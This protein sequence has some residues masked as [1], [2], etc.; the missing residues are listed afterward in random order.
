VC[1]RICSAVYS[2]LEAALN[3]VGQLVR[4]S[5]EIEADRRKHV[6]LLVQCV[7]DDVDHGLESLLT[8]LHSWCALSPYFHQ[9]FFQPCQQMVQMLV[10]NSGIADAF[11]QQVST[12]LQAAPNVFLL[13]NFAGSPNSISHERLLRTV[14]SWEVAG[15][16]LTEAVE[17]ITL[18]NVNPVLRCEGA[19]S[20]VSGFTQLPVVTVPL[21]TM[22]HIDVQME[23]SAYMF[24]EIANL[25]SLLSC[26]ITICGPTSH[27]VISTESVAGAVV[28]HGC[29]LLAKLQ[30]L[31][32][33]DF[34]SHP[35][36]FISNLPCLKHLTSKL[37]SCSPRVF[38]LSGGI[39]S[40][41]SIFDRNCVA[42][43][44]G[45][46]RF[47]LLSALACGIERGLAVLDVSHL[48]SLLT[49]EILSFISWP[50]VVRTRSDVSFVAKGGTLAE[51]LVEI[52][53][54][55]DERPELCKQCTPHVFDRW[56]A[57]PMIIHQYQR[58]SRLGLAVTVSYAQF[59][60]VVR[61]V[62]V[63]RMSS[64][65]VGRIVQFAYRKSEPLHSLLIGTNEGSASLGQNWWTGKW[66]NLSAAELVCSLDA[67]SCTVISVDAV[68]LK[69][70]IVRA[71][72]VA[73]VLSLQTASS[74]ESVCLGTDCQVFVAHN[75]THPPRP[76]SWTSLCP[77]LSY[78]R[79][80]QSRI[81][82]SGLSCGQFNMC[83]ELSANRLPQADDGQRVHRELI[84]GRG[85]APV[86]ATNSPEANDGLSAFSDLVEDRG[87][88]M[89][90]L[91]NFYSAYDRMGEGCDPVSARL[92]KEWLGRV[93]F[94]YDIA[95]DGIYA[96][97]VKAVFADEQAGESHADRM[98]RKNLDES[99]SS[100]E[101]DVSDDSDAWD[102]YDQMDIMED[103]SEVDSSL[104][105]FVI[106]DENG[107]DDSQA[108]SEESNND[109]LGNEDEDE[110]EYSSTEEESSEEE[111]AVSTVPKKS[112]KLQDDS[113]DE[114]QECD[115]RSRRQRYRKQSVVETSSSDEKEEKDASAS[116][117]R[118]SM[119]RL[120][121]SRRSRFIEHTAEEVSDDTS[122]GDS[123][124]SVV[125]SDN[126]S[127][128][129]RSSRDPH[130][131]R[132]TAEESDSSQDALRETSAGSKLSTICEKKRRKQVLDSDS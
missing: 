70:L 101:S 57:A 18:S 17:E 75:N 13:W 64:D 99:E 127:V 87:A 24:I 65:V 78:L 30:V 21:S 123:K 122:D 81:S 6:T 1:I 113:A 3:S 95:E 100:I 106:D 32:H 126:S 76:G 118:V 56:T 23:Y 50:M 130:Y 55:C 112:R 90:C 7:A 37:A 131:L 11:C 104:Q 47:R 16:P 82:W 120:S 103:S 110:A 33:V 20:K 66:G 117:D 5:Q 31:A 107:G 4:E 93:F 51:E 84:S 67:P 52:L 27:G 19:L 79:T 28:V 22:C 129:E 40:S 91:S 41:R 14:Q 36:L 61:P 116:H 119:P 43:G 63:L 114:T 72:S 10:D 124:S 15:A 73:V 59:S 88:Y 26:S 60:D 39:R 92:P 48:V 46:D 29:P 85:D 58:D 80:G 94:A 74:V 125:D 9:L 25:A 109:A 132:A 89:S 35:Q 98:A 128:E 38:D 102:Q 54:E 34:E 121:S 42:L 45:C 97:H 77:R 8:E 68:G 12:E 2:V 96:R 69:R 83:G 111:R 53:D 44:S 49:V 105:E 115:S 108:D 71:Q 62:A 86:E